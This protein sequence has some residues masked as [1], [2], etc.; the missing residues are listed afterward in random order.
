MSDD[1]EAQEAQEAAQKAFDLARPPIGTP[2]FAARLT[3]NHICPMVDGLKPHVGGPILSVGAPSVLIGG[4]VAA[5]VGTFCTC[6]SPAP[7]SILKG[8]PTVLIG[9]MMAA[10][11]GDTTAHGGMIVQGCPTVII[12]DGGGSGMDTP[13][14]KQST[15]ESEGF[16]TRLFHDIRDAF[17]VLRNRLTGNQWEQVQAAIS[18]AQKK[19]T[20]KK[21]KLTAGDAE[22][23][24]AM[25]EW[26][27][28]SDK[29]TKEAMAKRIDK[30]LEILNT[31]NSDNFD[32]DHTLVADGKTPEFAHVYHDDASHRISLGDKFWRAPATGSD[33]QMGTI[34]HELSHFDE[35]GHTDD[36]VYGED[37]ARTLAKESPDDAIRNA[38]NF[39]YFIEDPR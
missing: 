23:E 7:D 19:L 4:L 2:L 34:T 32:I 27:G 35:A 18:N 21:A 36:V 26:F 3:D 1:E 17:N 9:G 5:N 31:L 6:A 20:E 39:E 22:T 12:G 16:F 29:A 25:N 38:D 33:S 11:L 13:S 37:N 14:A 15:E 28:R 30:E 24:A 8:S 10:R